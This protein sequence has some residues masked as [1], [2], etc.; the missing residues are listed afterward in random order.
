[1]SKIQQFLTKNKIFPIKVF[2]L[3][4]QVIVQPLLHT[5]FNA[6]FSFFLPPRCSECD[7]IYAYYKSYLGCKSIQLYV[8]IYLSQY[9]KQVFHISNVQV[10]YKIESIFME[11]LKICIQMP[12]NLKSQKNK[13]NC[14]CNYII[15]QIQ[16]EINSSQIMMNLILI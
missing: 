2:D 6:L 5:D 1:M 13:G 4:V 9:R 7:Y 16:F 8:Y 11:R 15:M 10:N 3:K 14:A 12:S